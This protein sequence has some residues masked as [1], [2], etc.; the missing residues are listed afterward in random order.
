MLVGWLGWRARL[1][2]ETKARNT[3]GGLFKTFEFWNG[4]YYSQWTSTT[5]TT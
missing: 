4:T 1:I 5:F 3:N 2:L